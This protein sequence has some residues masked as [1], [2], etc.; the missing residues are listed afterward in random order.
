[1][2]RIGPFQYTHKY[3]N[4]DLGGNIL[5]EKLI[6]DC[7]FLA[8]QTDPKGRKAAL[9]SPYLRQIISYDACDNLISI[10]EDDQLFAS[11]C[12]TVLHFW[13]YSERPIPD[14]LNS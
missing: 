4:Y 5:H 2:T 10:E 6:G 12:T 3:E 8:Y 1:M 14:S 11:K 9:L 7:G 13:L